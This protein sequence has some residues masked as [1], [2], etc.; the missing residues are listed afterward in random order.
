MCSLTAAYSQLQSC[1]LAVF[2]LERE[3]SRPAQAGR[4]EALNRTDTRQ[5]L[6]LYAISRVLEPSMHRID[7]DD[8]D[9][10]DDR[11]GSFVEDIVVNVDRQ[12]TL[13]YVCSK[14]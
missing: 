2:V 9:V 7:V 1:H 6:L 8:N 11:H 3:P 14:C 13:N 5:L 10:D 4:V 12:A